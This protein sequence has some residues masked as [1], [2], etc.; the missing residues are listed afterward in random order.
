VKRI[1]LISVLVLCFSLAAMAGDDDRYNDLGNK[2][3]CSC[4][5]GQ[6][7]IKCNHVGC[8]SSD[9]MIRQ[10]RSAVNNYSNDEDVLNWFRRTYG[11][12][13]VVAPSTHGFELTIWIMPLVLA[14][15]G[16]FLLFLISRRWRSRATPI[17]VVHLDP[18][19]E[20]LRNRARKET[21][22]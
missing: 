19:L 18:Q 16:I 11:M 1:T 3:Q 17:G 15:A 12:T 7:L 2:I 20:E 22:I 8:P 10:L 9:G 13:V 4:G 5:C 21:E 6:I 14:A